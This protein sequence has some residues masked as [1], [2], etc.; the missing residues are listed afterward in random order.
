MRPG[1]YSWTGGG[2]TFPELTGRPR[3]VTPRV[4][5][6][7]IKLREDHATLHSVVVEGV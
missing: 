2:D 6:L 1:S 3:W 5:V 7:P 4:C